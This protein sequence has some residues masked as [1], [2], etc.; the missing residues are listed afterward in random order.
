MHKV[1]NVTNTNIRSNTEQNSFK[2]AISDLSLTVFSGKR[3]TNTS[4]NLSNK[5]LFQEVS[6]NSCRCLISKKLTILTFV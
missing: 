1:S 4:D 3:L 5:H 2:I 6:H